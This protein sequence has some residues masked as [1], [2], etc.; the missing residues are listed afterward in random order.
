MRERQKEIRRRR[1]RQL[2]RQ[3]KRARTLRIQYSNKPAAAV[4]PAPALAAPEH[5]G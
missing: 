1:Q 4:P 3:K 2:K 5:S